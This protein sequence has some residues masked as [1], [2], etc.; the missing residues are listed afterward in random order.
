MPEM[1]AHW[2]EQIKSTVP[3]H[4]LDETATKQGVILNVCDPQSP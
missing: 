4:S 2:V 1:I 3:F